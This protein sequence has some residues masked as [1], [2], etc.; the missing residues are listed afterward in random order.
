MTDQNTLPDMRTD[1]RRQ[2][3]FTRPLVEALVILGIFAVVGAASG[4]LWES[5]WTAPTGVVYHGKWY[6][7]GAGTDRMFDGTGSF[8]VIATLVGLL[9]GLICAWVFTASEIVTVV[10]VLAGG[11]VAAWLMH[12]VG[13][14]LGPADPVTRAKDAADFTKVG[15]TLRTYGDGYRV[16]F[17]GGALIGSAPVYLRFLA[18][19][20]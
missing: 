10:A 12:T 14:H 1:A 18:R 8:V 7:D 9:L 2:R 3:S 19:R 4:W 15:G 13:V 16:A 11:A 17:P 5:R 6:P 20:R